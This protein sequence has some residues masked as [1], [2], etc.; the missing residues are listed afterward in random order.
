MPLQSYDSLNALH[1]DVLQEIG[2][3]GAGN[4][5][6]A[7]STMISSKVDMTPPKVRILSFAEA[8]ESSG[9]A[10]NVGVGILLTLS[11]DINGMI[12][13]IIEEN[14]AHKMVNLLL[15]QAL[16]SFEDNDEMSK[17][18]LC[19]IGN[20]MG[21]SFINAIATMTGMAIDISTPSLAIDMMGAILSV[22][23]IIFG[24]VGDKVLFI[25][26][27]FTDS[28]ETIKSRVALIPDVE[29]LNKILTRLGIE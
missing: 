28:V 18:A 5:L 21:A 7:L 14:F 22:P 2:N 19:E 17:S 16:L 12:M 29:S 15:S 25:E 6:T 10:E 26:E 3:I 13:F 8:V 1:M 9:G 11:G 24:E 4:S 20:I 27:E 23:A